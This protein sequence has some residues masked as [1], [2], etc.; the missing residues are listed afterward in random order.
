MIQNG[1]IQDGK[2]CSTEIKC[3]MYKDSYIY[4][5]FGN[6]KNA[7]QLDYRNAFL[8]IATEILYS[9]Y[10]LLFHLYVRDG[11]ILPVHLF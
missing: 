1:K 11:T 6:I 8:F 9:I 2:T 7:F 10:I 4:F 3:A 5:L